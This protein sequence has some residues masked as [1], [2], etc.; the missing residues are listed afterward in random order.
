ML[1]VT[2][3]ATQQIEQYFKDKDVSPIR[4]FLNEGGWGGPGLA[5]ALD[6]PKETDET[7]EIE[8]FQYI[9]DKDFMQKVQPIK[10]D[11]Q[12]YGFK[13]DCGIDFG[14]GGCAGCG[15]ASDS[16]EVW[17]SAGLDK[18]INHIW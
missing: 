16:C 17:Q 2:T 12:A 15:S 1:E 18:P 4:I 5:M 13:L 11:F 14:A 6:E 7:I 3:A 10:V 9:V 8:G